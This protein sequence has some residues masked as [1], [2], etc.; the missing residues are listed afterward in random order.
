MNY[1][2]RT[3]AYKIYAVQGNEGFLDPVN[4]IH[5]KTLKDMFLIFFLKRF[6]DRTIEHQTG[7]FTIDY[8]IDRLIRNFMCMRENIFLSKV[9]W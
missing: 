3:L 4:N 6:P 7:I 9:V 1:N 2:T 5:S 8:P